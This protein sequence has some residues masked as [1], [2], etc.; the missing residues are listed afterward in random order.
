VNVRATAAGLA[1]AALGL[2]AAEAPPPVLEIHNDLGK[3]VDELY[4]QP[5]GDGHWVNRLAP[6]VPLQPGHWAE[7]ALDPARGCIYTIEA[8]FN[9]GE[10][11]QASGLNLC[12]DRDAFRLSHTREMAGF[13]GHGPVTGP[14]GDP[15]RGLPLCPGDVR[16]RKKP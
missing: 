14:P 3:P 2:G 4:I 12:G 16:C 7:A 9:D 11:R 15:A 8:R 1:L 10:M 13:P 5:A 6:R